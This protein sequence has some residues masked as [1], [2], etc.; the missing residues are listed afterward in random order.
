MASQHYFKH[1]ALYIQFL[2]HDTE[3]FIGINHVAHM[4]LISEILVV[5][6]NNHLRAI[7]QFDRA[8]LWH[9]TLRVIQHNMLSQ[10]PFAFWKLK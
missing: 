10:K 7:C 6:T 2:L 1:L 5:Q 9:I 4:I 8:K 3:Y